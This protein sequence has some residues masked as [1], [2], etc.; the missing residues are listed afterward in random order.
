MCSCQ[1]YTMNQ[2]Y[3][4]VKKW[5][6][7]SHCANWCRYIC[8]SKLGGRGGR[9]K[10]SI[11][12]EDTL[13]GLPIRLN[14]IISWDE[15]DVSKF[16]DASNNT[17]PTISCLNCPNLAKSGS[18]YY[19]K[20]ILCTGTGTNYDWKPMFFLLLNLIGEYGFLLHWAW[21]NGLHNYQWK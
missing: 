20:V 3:L 18:G 14:Y 13:S 11:V 5:L 6:R 10:I 19:Q 16:H 7:W 9:V 12:N 21:A 8:T 17:N 15:V 1:W 2:I 4:T